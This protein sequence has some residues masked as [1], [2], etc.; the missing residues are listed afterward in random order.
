MP[1][2]GFGSEEHPVALD[3]WQEIIEVGWG[4]VTHAAFLVSVL[5]RNPTFE[6]PFGTSTVCSPVER[7]AED[8]SAPPHTVIGHSLTSLQLYN[9]GTVVPGGGII[10][11]VQFYRRNRGWGSPVLV[12]VTGHPEPPAT[13]SFAPWTYYDAY[14][15]TS[16]GGYPQH[17]RRFLQIGG[18]LAS[19]DDIPV[20]DDPTKGFGPPNAQHEIYGWRFLLGTAPF[21]YSSPDPIPRRGGFTDGTGELIDPPSTYLGWPETL[22]NYDVGNFVFESGG[23]T[24][25][26]VGAYAAA[27]SVLL[28]VLCERV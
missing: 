1:P 21:C 27:N 25:V 23:M 9:G 10:E 26:G 11:S 18:D 14:P 2:S 4:R 3:P 7:A 22:I 24:F 8:Y 6:P 12:E 5:T 16:F 20:P 28:W 13:V 15:E 17:R 19:D